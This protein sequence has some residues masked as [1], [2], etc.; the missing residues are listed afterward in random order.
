M[1]EHGLLNGPG[2]TMCLPPC[3]GK[4]VHTEGMSHGLAVLVEGRG[5]SKV[6]FEPIPKSPSQFLNILLLTIHLGIFVPV[7]YPTQYGVGESLSPLKLHILYF[8]SKWLI[9]LRI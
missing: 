9:I 6:F 2:D 4:T 7:N 3:Y 5:K 1:D 8:S